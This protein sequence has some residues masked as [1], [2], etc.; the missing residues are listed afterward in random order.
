MEDQVNTNNMKRVIAGIGAASLLATVM[1]VPVTAAPPGGTSRNITVTGT[2]DIFSAPAGDVAMS[3]GEVVSFSVTVRNGGPQTVNN[4]SLVFGLD[5]NPAPQANGDATPPSLFP[6]GISVTEDSASCTGGQIVN[7]TIGTLGARKE[8]TTSIT[9]STTSI[10]PAGLTLVEAVASVAEAGGDSGYNIDTFSDQGDIVIVGFDCDATT[11][12]RPG[13]ASKT[14]T[15]CAIGTGGDDPDANDQSTAITIPSRLSAAAI[16]EILGDNCPAAS[17]NSECVGD[18]VEVNIT[19]ETTSDVIFWEM[20]IDTNGANVTLQKLYF[21]HTDAGGATPIS[22]TKK[23]ACKSL[24]AT[25][26]GSASL[27]GTILTVKVQTPGN[28][29]G[30]VRL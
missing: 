1:A 7:C 12:Y 8:F 15:T 17:D 27:S 23:N 20:R 13:G 25:N 16:S 2:T 28:G 5:D 18:E 24:T 9:L 10:A 19:G 11:A 14:I 21:V 26:C 6:T 22:L 3:A 29:S 4:I 30:R